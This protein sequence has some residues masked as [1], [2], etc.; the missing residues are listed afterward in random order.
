MTRAS[1]TQPESRYAGIVWSAMWVGFI[2]ALVGLADG[3][4]I[5]L[6]RRVVTCLTGTYF[7]PGT[8]NFT[9]YAHPNAGTGT[10]IAVIAV[11]LG[12]L[13]AL[14]AVSAATGLRNGST[15][16]GVSSADHQASSS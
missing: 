12:I 11:L 3:F 8:T 6:E 13:V 16:L 10:A 4:E 7:P 9:C 1:G 14:S 5:A 2:L 15:A